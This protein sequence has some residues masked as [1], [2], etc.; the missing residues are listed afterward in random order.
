VNVKLVLPRPLRLPLF[1]LGL[2]A[3]FALG[4]NNAVP[5][6][7]HID[8][9]AQSCVDNALSMSFDVVSTSV[10]FPG[11]FVYGS[12]NVIPIPT[13]SPVTG[14]F[15]VVA[16][17]DTVMNGEG[18][19]MAFSAGAYPNGNIT[20]QNIQFYTVPVTQVAPP[21]CPP[22]HGPTIG[23]STSPGLGFHMEVSNSGPDPLFIDQ[24]EMAETPTLLPGSEMHWGGTDF[25]GLT[26]VPSPVLP[27]GVV[28]APG[29][30][31]FILDLPE[32][33]SAGSAGVLM[34]YVS[35]SSS[36]VESRAAV[37]VDLSSLPVAVQPSTWGK[38]KSLYH[39]K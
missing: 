23:T 9:N 4:C 22:E 5:V 11:V 30:P 13:T 34:R 31:P 2:G 39:A 17:L 3:V 20:I 15:H 36:G 16:A 35:H 18:V 37:Q 7:T 12:S 27:P 14:G 6:E 1:Y 19:Q 21:A 8:V 38:V 29:S 24:L 33:P 26:W 32:L 28:L 25:E 10:M